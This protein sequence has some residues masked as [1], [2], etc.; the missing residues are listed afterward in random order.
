MSSLGLIP[1]GE[2]CPVLK[3][4]TERSVEGGEYEIE[5]DMQHG[6]SIYDVSESTLLQS[7][8]PKHDNI[9][10]FD[11]LELSDIDLKKKYYWYI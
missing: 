6:P 8:I 1:G 5:L 9:A 7:F 4:A 3:R 11:E 2:P 10:S